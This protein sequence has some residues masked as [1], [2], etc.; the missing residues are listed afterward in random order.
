MQTWMEQARSLRIGSKRKVVCCG[1]DP[2]ALISNGDRGVRIHCFRCGRD[3]F[4]PHPKRSIAEI[5][6]SRRALD[7]LADAPVP[8]MPADAVLLSDGPREG[9]QWVLRGGLTPELAEDRYGFRWH[10]DTRR[11]L[12]PVPGGILARAV[13]GER[14]KY[15]MLTNRPGALYWPGERAGAAVVVVEDILSAIAIERA[16]WPAVAVLGTSIS[17]VQ[18]AEIA[19]GTRHVIGW[20]DGDDAGDRAWVRL[21]KRM[22]LYAPRVTRIR[23]DK[24]PKALHRGVLRALLTEHTGA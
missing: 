1:A 13:N 11:V 20:F 3:E 15:R 17:D 24:D 12:I 18:A 4:V 6:A 14:P 16:G 8:K 7:A 23:T 21:R 10:E 22:A 2:S 9:W 19:A 5:L